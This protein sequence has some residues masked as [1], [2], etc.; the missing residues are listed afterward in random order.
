M[1]WSKKVFF[2]ILTGLFFF[3]ICFLYVKPTWL[4]EISFTKIRLRSH[5]QTQKSNISYTALQSS[6]NVEMEHIALCPEIPTNLGPKV[7]DISHESLSNIALENPNVQIG[8]RSKPQ[9]CIAQ[10][11][12][13]II[14]PFRNREHHLQIWLHHMHPFLQKQQGDYGIYVIEQIE[15]TTFNKAKLM[16]VCFKEAAKDY[17]YNC[18]IFSDVDII[19][20]DERNLYRCS[21]N[22]KHMANSLDKFNFRLPYDTIFGGVVAFTKEQ[23]LKIN[24]FSNRFWGWGGEDDEL[25]NRVRSVGM[26]VERPDQVIARS[27]MIFHK[28]DVGNEETGKSTHHDNGLPHPLHDGT[29][30]SR[31]E[32]GSP[33]RKR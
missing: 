13:A 15:N 14:I 5:F 28:R 22:P 10:Q 7:V 26:R 32:S 17:D 18:F 19:P 23:F 12:I 1:S 8:G 27:R 2:Y 31:H 20:M 33:D 24:G 3:S 11:K 6:E 16:N 30:S 4:L 21:K 25:Y 29:G 9:T